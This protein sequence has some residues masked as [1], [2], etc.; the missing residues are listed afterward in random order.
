M[1][2]KAAAWVHGTIV[3]VENPGLLAP[4]ISMWKRGWGTH[5][6]GKEESYNW[7]HIPFTTPV[8]VDNI[9]PTLAKVFVFYKT[10][11]WAKITNV[12]VYDGP[13]KVKTFEGLA[14][15]GDHS[16]AID[17]SNSWVINPPIQIMYGLGLSVGVEFGPVDNAGMPWPEIL[18][19][20]AG[21][22]FQTP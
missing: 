7:F 21:A 20:A 4:I 22:D 16:T 18:F 1:A 12:H 15:S 5:F 8:I 19:T 11:G 14:L 17:A 13:R 2:L 9:R 3:E 10:D 6:W